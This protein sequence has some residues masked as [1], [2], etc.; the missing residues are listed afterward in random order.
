MASIYGF[1]TTTDEK[2]VF[3]RL[4]EFHGVNEHVARERL[5]RIKIEHALFVA[6]AI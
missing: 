4:V 1:R 5:H 6:I 2:V 3:Q